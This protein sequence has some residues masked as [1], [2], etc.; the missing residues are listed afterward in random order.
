M[1]T[2]R[3]GQLT[4]LIAPAQLERSPRLALGIHIHLQRPSRLVGQD[5]T[6][7]VI[8]GV[9]GCFGGGE[10]DEGEATVLGLCARGVGC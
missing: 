3:K 5:I 9:E 8:D 10:G 6:M 7:H 4:S 2:K 1:R